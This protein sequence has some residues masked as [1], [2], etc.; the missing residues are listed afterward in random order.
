MTRSIYQEQCSTSAKL[1]GRV[2]AGQ[3]NLE[4]ALRGD[5][6]HSDFRERTWNLQ[7]AA[8]PKL[9]QIG[10]DGTPAMSTATSGTSA[11]AV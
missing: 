8:Q 2:I 10:P 3:G 9:L 11:P 4:R 6:A 5:S 7:E 1:A